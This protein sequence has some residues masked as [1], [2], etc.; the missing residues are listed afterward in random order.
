[1]LHF[2]YMHTRAYQENIFPAGCSDSSDDEGGGLIGNPS[3]MDKESSGAS[4]SETTDHFND[5][6]DNND[7]SPTHG[8]PTEVFQCEPG[9]RFA[10]L[11]T[12]PWVTP[13]KLIQEG[14]MAFSATSTQMYV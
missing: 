6:A 10:L 12:W 4:E 8:Q 7:A 11:L 9:I 13:Y 1:M 14:D 3:D 5:K 2:C